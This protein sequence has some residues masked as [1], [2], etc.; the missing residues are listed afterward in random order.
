MRKETDQG[1]K[2][3]NNTINSDTAKNQLK[4]SFYKCIQQ[5]Y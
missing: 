3:R 4:L 1:N 2:I 5:L